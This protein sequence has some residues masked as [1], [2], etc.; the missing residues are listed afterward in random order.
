MLV[1]KKYCVRKY[2]S[3]LASYLVLEGYLPLSEKWI[4]KCGEI[5]SIAP[6]AHSLFQDTQDMNVN[7]PKQGCMR[8]IGTLLSGPLCFEVRLFVL[9][10]DDIISPYWWIF[11]NIGIT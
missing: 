8:E 2:L 10:E 6:A 4:G 5:I 3:H 9:E 1:G 11:E 7:I